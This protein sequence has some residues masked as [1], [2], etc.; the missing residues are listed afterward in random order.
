MKKEFFIILIVILIV[1]GG[2]WFLGKRQ[3]Q[4]PSSVTNVLPT[5]NTEITNASQTTGTIENKSD[6]VDE[7]KNQIALTV[8]Q[9]TDGQTTTSSFITV[10]GK[11][12]SNADVSVNDMDLKADTQGNFSATL[13][14]DEG[15]ND[16]VVV[17]VD[18]KGL[19]AEKDLTVTYDTGQQ[20]N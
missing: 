15:D 9:P 5:E 2:V 17:A 1:V 14:L 11:T 20:Y 19:S 12:V 4:S 3:N 6:K 7:S 16:I 8:S 18:N 10:K 13:T